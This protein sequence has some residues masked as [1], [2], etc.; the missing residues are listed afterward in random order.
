MHGL[1][2]CVFVLWAPPFQATFKFVLD[3]HCCGHSSGGSIFRRETGCA[4]VPMSGN[5]A[6]DKRFV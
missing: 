4:K 3:F 6:K 5:C 1:G 2:M